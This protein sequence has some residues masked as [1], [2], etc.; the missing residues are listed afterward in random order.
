[1]SNV[2]LFAPS[3][4][5]RVMAGDTVYIITNGQ[6]VVPERFA[7]SLLNA[8]FTMA[9]AG[10]GVTL[11]TAG[12]GD[13]VLVGVLSDGAG[14]T[15]GSLV[16]NAGVAIP[17]V[18]ASSI[19]PRV[20]ALATLLAMTGNIGEIMAPNDAKGLV[21]QNAP[22]VGGTQR[23]K[24]LEVYSASMPFNFTTTPQNAVVNSCPFRPKLA[25][26]F[27][28]LNGGGTSYYVGFFPDGQQ[29]YGIYN[30]PGM[31]VDIGVDALP[32]I[33]EG[34]SLVTTQGAAGDGIQDNGF[35]FSGIAT[36]IG[37]LTATMAFILIG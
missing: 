13:T 14:G 7:S 18:K 37:T 19:V 8:G 15:D 20:N 11:A 25:I 10:G 5:S 23:L 30:I 33:K 31:A 24:P 36:D 22:G 28:G 17:K 3:G 12:N 34:T 27:L 4:V 35:K 9:A 1:M 26:V 32:V 21:V 16:D 6:V 2:T 29:S